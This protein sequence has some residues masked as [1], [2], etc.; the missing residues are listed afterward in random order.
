M[1]FSKTQILS[2]FSSNWVVA[3]C[4][5]FHAIST[6]LLVVNREQTAN[7]KMYNPCSFDGTMWIFPRSL[8][9]FKSFSFSSSVL[10]WKEQ[11]IKV[12]IKHTHSKHLNYHLRTYFHSETNQAQQN[13]GRDLKS[14]ILKE[15]F[16]KFMRQCNLS[17]NMLLKLLGPI[18]SHN[19]PQLQWTESSSQRNL[20]VLDKENVKYIN[21]CK[22]R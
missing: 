9:L 3:S 6:S 17:T 10:F 4:I 22:F 12:R 14:G 1:K 15:K 2:H 18:G 11:K 7:R 8:M 13:W 20:P 21:V 5:S 16:F 19:K